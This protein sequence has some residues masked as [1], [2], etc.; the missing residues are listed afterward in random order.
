VCPG[1]HNDCLETHDLVLSFMRVCSSRQLCTCLH[2][3]QSSSIA[4]WPWA[5][6]TATQGIPSWVETR[7]HNA[8][9]VHLASLANGTLSL[10]C[11]SDYA[12]YV[13]FRIA[14]Y[15]IAPTVDCTSLKA[16][17]TLDCASETRLVFSLLKYT[18]TMCLCT[19]SNSQGYVHCK[20][21]VM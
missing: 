5:D 12:P 16:H 17:L 14:Q 4:T 3:H 1:S 13:P 6:T 20:L 11:L 9:E 2:S 19:G 7:R 21:R 18:Y 8:H 10:F 15:R